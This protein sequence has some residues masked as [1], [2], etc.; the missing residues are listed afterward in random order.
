MRKLPKT[1]GGGVGIGKREFHFRGHAV[2]FGRFTLDQATAARKS[3]PNHWPRI[4]VAEQAFLRRW[5]ALP[6][7]DQGKAPGSKGRPL[8]LENIYA[9]EAL[10]RAGISPKN[11]GG[12]IECRS[13]C[14][15]LFVQRSKQVFKSRPFSSAARCR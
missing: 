7:T 15:R 6:S 11:A 4:F 9:S 12:E 1:R 13:G 2:I 8:A 10:F 3:V 14:R 5:A